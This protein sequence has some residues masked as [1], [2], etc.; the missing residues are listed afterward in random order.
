MARPKKKES[1]AKENVL[2][3]RLTDD[4]RDTIDR[5]AAAKSLETSTWARS[6][7]M[8][9]AKRLLARHD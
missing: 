5:A 2:R 3:I 9:L 7:L 8:T 6:E 1:E 4:E